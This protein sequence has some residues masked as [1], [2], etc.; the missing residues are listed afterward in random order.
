MSE[1]RLFQVLDEMNVND[2]VNKTATCG[3]CFDLVAANKVKEG[4]HVTMGVP[5]E[6]VLKIF[7]GE[8]QPILILLDKKEYERIKKQ[9]SESEV[10]P[11]TEA[12]HQFLNECNLYPHVGGA[13]K[14]LTENDEGAYIDRDEILKLADILYRYAKTK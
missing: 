11:L 13:L 6:A 3:C 10:M 5:T 7:L 1:K 4:G 12:E 2:E 14:V 8:Y 9:K